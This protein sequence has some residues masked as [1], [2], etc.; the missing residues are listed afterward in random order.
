MKAKYLYLLFLLYLP[1]THLSAADIDKVTVAIAPSTG[2]ANAICDSVA[3]GITRG[4]KYYKDNGTYSDISVIAAKKVAKTM[5][6]NGILVSDLANDQSLMRVGQLMNTDLIAMAEIT[7]DGSVTVKLMNVKNGDY[8][9]VNSNQYNSI[10]S[11]GPAIQ[12]I[13]Y[14]E[15]YKTDKHCKNIGF[16]RNDVPIAVTGG[17]AGYW[18]F[19]DQT[20]KD[21][22]DYENTSSI[23][24]TK[25]QFTTNTPSGYGFACVENYLEVKEHLLNAARWTVCMWVYF[26]KK[27]RNVIQLFSEQSE[28]DNVNYFG[29][30]AKITGKT[31]IL[32]KVDHRLIR[33]PDGK[34]R[35]EKD[36]VAIQ[37][38][39]YKD[40]NRKEEFEEGWHHVAVKK[41]L[42]SDG[43]TVF[44][45]YVD[46]I[47][48]EIT[49]FKRNREYEGDLFM[50]WHAPAY[51]NVRLYERALSYDEIN[52]IYKS[53]QQ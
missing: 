9:F 44:H 21:V 11:L 33:Q 30:E 36:G 48:V 1:L 2:A 5:Q 19:D 16:I 25:P 39:M 49:F 52:E 38:A 41:E 35:T 42:L 20:G 24:G 28:K 12:D 53:E 46:G 17:L 40:V 34:Y 27:M 37:G 6:K 4:L 45:Y 50:G 14:R 22:S 13:F 18:T 32:T 51:D 43:Q 31:S 23:G 7:S 10:V 29:Y 47:S 26:P 15:I 3:N 8:L